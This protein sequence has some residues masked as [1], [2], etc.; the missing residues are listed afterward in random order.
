M[1]STGFTWA[2]V[3]DLERG[4]PNLGATMR[5]EIYRLMQFAVR[6]AMAQTLVPEAAVRIFRDAGY[7]FGRAF[8]GHAIRPSADLGEFSVTISEDA[9]R[10][11]LPISHATT[12]AYDEG[13]IAALSE[14]FCGRRFVVKEID[15]W[16]SGD[17]TCRFIASALPD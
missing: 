4:R 1:E 6:D 2:S 15:G 8:R 12:C 7:A 17:R 9:G 16:S 14:S 11:G 13:V 5:V 10:S 3:G